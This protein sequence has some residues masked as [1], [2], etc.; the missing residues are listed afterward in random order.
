M[1]S[2]S[3]NVFTSPKKYGKSMC[4]YDAMCIHSHTI[5]FLRVPDICTDYVHNLPDN[6]T[7]SSCVR[8]PLP[9]EKTSRLG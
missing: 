9:F 4:F 3:I 8:G 7:L 5:V 6:S 1:T 2:L